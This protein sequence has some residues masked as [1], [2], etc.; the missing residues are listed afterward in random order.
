[1]CLKSV[2]ESK[3]ENCLEFNDLVE[4]QGIYQV[5]VLLIVRNIIMFT[6]LDQLSQPPFRSPLWRFDIGMHRK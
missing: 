1:M 5:F 2:G 3:E 4:G 6:V